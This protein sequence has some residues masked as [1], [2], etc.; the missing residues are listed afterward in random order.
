MD[1]GGALNQR[2]LLAAA[3][4]APVLAGCA[5]LPA[6]NGRDQ[7][8]TLVRERGLDVSQLGDAEAARVLLA[9]LN[10]KPLGATDVVRLALIN[11]PKLKAEYARLG[12]AAADVYDAGRLSN[13]VFSAAVLYPDV[14][15]QASQVTLGLVQSFT[16][17]LL[18][19]S[20]G[21]FARGEFQRMQ[22][23]VGAVTVNLAADAEAAYF[24]LV[25]ALQLRALRV[26]IVT[27]AQA[28][29][30]LAQR[31]F[32]AGNISRLELALEQA[33]GAQARLEAMGADFEVTGAR[34]E[35]NRLMGFETDEQDWQVTTELAAV[36]E[37]SS[38][39]A[40][41]PDLL[42]RA[43]TSRL[44]LAAARARSDLTVKAFGVTHGTRLLGKLNAGIETERET[45]DARITGPTLAL[46]LPIFNAG[47][48]RVARAEAQWRSAEAELHALEIQISNAVRL[49][50]AGV[51]AARGRAEHY[52]QTLIPLREAIVAR[53]QED[54]NYM[55]RGQ[56]ELLVAKQQ[57][58]AAYHG[59]IEAVRDYW[60]ARVQLAREV[61][62]PLP[63]SGLATGTP[64]AVPL[65]GALDGSMPPPASHEQAPPSGEPTHEHGDTR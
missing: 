19:R 13:P 51:G 7:V 38:S 22:Q 23:S 8:M 26:A 18:L 32:D 57:E 9:E 20:R 10:G 59:Y 6:D 29:A 53:T 42:A 58:Y 24:R 2:I 27:S 46:E 4:A 40:A 21:K 62:G 43:R 37:A 31:F 65:P 60:L 47:R 11:N 56:F 5:S 35:L 49:A 55:L 16:D 45:D 41:L 25:G 64:L 14:S 44:D 63:A 33:A 54:V 61:G 15:G 36:P 48:G 34:T 50:H 3:I 30:D 1:G 52:R 17:V 28:S 12:F 39:D